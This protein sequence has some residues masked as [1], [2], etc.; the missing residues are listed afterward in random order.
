M[1]LLAASARTSSG[2]AD[3]LRLD[4]LGD[5]P[6]HSRQRL[7]GADLD[8]LGHALRRPSRRRS[9]ASAPARSPARPAAAGSPRDRSPPR[10]STL[11]TSG[12]D[13]RRDRHLRPAPPPSPPPPAASARNGTARSPAAAAPASRRAPWRSPPPAP[14]PPGR[15]TPPPAPD[16]CRSPPRRP[17]PRA[18]SAATASAAA[19]SS[20]SSAAIAPSPTGTASCIACAAQ[21]QHPRGVGERHRPR[22]AERRIFPQR[23]PGDEGRRRS[24]PKP[25]ASIARIAAIEVAISAGCAFRVSVSAAIVA[26]PD[27]RRQ[28]LARA[29]RPPRRTPP[30]PPD[31]PRARSRP[32]PTTCAPL[33]RK[34]ECPH[35]VPPVRWISP[36]LAAR[37]GGVHRLSA[38]RGPRPRR[39]SRR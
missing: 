15:P 31:R 1:P 27:Q 18:A 9:R 19:R 38:R 26:L 3:R 33:P 22:G 6:D 36:F 30:A 37:R 13:R 17:R 32:M 7:A 24:T 39:A 5:P 29:P 25:S 8:R 20:P 23:M 11:A 35:L 28:L 14:P 2:R 12:T 21:P 16:R 4:L 10:P 34:D